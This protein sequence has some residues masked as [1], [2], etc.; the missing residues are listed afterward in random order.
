MIRLAIYYTPPPDSPLADGAR[1]WLGRDNI[2]LAYKD[3]Q[4]TFGLSSNRFRKIIASPFHY[5]FHGTLKPPFRLNAGVT[6]KAVQNKLE[7]FAKSCQNFVLPPL[8][9]RAIDSFFCLRPTEDSEVLKRLAASVVE[10]FDEFR[11]PPDSDELARRR[12]AGLTQHQERLLSTWGYPYVME[13]FRFHLTLTGR[14]ADQGERALIN[15]E[16]KKRF[17]TDMLTGLP[18]SALSLFIEKNGE[19]MVLLD[20]YSF[21]S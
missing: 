6:V 11:L 15:A 20:K 10:A 2:S 19:P 18:F 9:V 5:G 7:R 8:E 4:P 17:T 13:E 21:G 12:A 16:L 14:I 1:R 3:Q